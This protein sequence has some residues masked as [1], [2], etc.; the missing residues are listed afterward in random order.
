M[1]LRERYSWGPR[2][3]H[4]TYCKVLAFLYYQALRRVI[5]ACADLRKYL[6]RCRYCRIFFFTMACNRGRTDL[7]C[8]FGCAET[9]RNNESLRRRKEYY[10]TPE[11]KVKKKELN[12][13]RKEKSNKNITRP[14][15]RISIFIF[16]LHYIVTQIEHTKNSISEV[17]IKHQGYLKILRQHSLEN[18]IRIKQDPDG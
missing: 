4:L 2:W 15:A 11:G 13:K 16:Y 5:Q 6:C 7:A 14:K 1:A 18:F 3:Y 12:K 8:P 17:K 9:H 10:Q